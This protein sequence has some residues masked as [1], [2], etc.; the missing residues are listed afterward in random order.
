MKNI[1]AILLLIVGFVSCKTADPCLMCT[2]TSVTNTVTKEVLVPVEVPAD[3]VL[4]QALI[5]CD[6]A[7]NIVLGELYELKS[8]GANTTVKTI[9]NR[10]V[11]KVLI[12]RDTIYLPVTSTITDKTITIEKPPI[13]LKE[14]IAWWVK[15]LAWLGVAA[16]LLTTVLTIQH[17]RRPWKR[18]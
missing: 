1:I 13:V 9:G 15:V 5:R 8:S 4:M 12:K 2:Q 11:Y 14:P 17:F 16:I 10:L 6:S 18:K 3:S 7:G